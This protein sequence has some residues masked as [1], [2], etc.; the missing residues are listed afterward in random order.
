MSCAVSSSA[1]GDS[2][3][4]VAFSLPRPSPAAARAAPVAPCRATSS[5]TPAASRRDG[6]RSRAG[7][8]R[9]SAGPRTRARAA[10]ARRA[11]RRSGATRRTLSPR[12]SRRLA[13]RRG[14]RAAAGARD[15][16]RARPRPTTRSTL[17]HSFA[18]GL[19]AVSVSRMPGL[20]L[21]HLAERPEADAVAVR[22]R[23]AL[24]PAR[25]VRRRVDD[26]RRARRRAGTCR[27]PARRPASRAAARAPRAPARARRRAARARAR[28]RRAAASVALLEID[29]EAASAPRPPPRPGPARALPFAAT[30]S[31]SR[32]SIA[33]RV[34]RYVVSPT[35]IAVHRRRGLQPRGSVDDVARRHPLALGRARAE[36]D[37]RL[38]GVDRDP[39]LQVALARAPSR[40]SRARRGR[41]A[42]DRPRARPARRRAP[43]PRRR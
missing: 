31:R 21:H 37:E 20:G 7:R 14:R 9:P 34:A 36:Q 25:Q 17:A 24:P 3:S 2:E 22:Q 19:A 33:S 39:H 38:A 32:Y 35:R 27:S 1:S 15:P 11:P 10:A 18:L 16:A 6:R 41:R 28:G 5:G 42:R 23:A 43:S 8:R 26:A 4:V 29:A 30:G 12:P 40:G 13:R